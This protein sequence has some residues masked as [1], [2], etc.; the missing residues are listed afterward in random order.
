MFALSACFRYLPIRTILAVATGLLVCGVATGQ[1]VIPGNTGPVVIPSSRPHVIPR[2]Q[3]QFPVYVTPNV[4]VGIN[5]VTGGV[6]TQNRQIDNTAYQYGRHESQFNGTKRWVRRPV[7]NAQGQVVG[8]QE[9]WVWINSYTGQ[10]HGEMVNYTPNGQGGVNSG[11]QTFAQPSGPGGVHQNVQSYSAQPQSQPQPQTGAPSGQ[12]GG[13]HENVQSYGVPSQPNAG[14]VHK[15][16]QSY[17]VQ[18]Q[19]TSPTQATPTNPV[20]ATSQRRLRSVIR[21]FVPSR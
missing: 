3:G 17:S 13:V 7:Y 19:T 4:I 11:H 9:G 15:N 14:G 8:Y 6:D 5:P 1:V 16:I 18:P 10:E 20:R 12:P 2:T 21:S